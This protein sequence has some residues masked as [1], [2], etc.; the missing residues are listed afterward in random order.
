[1]EIRE[2][3]IPIESENNII[4]NGNL[5]EQCQIITQCQIIITRERNENKR[6]I[7]K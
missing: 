5:R 4:K 3:I 6:G 1:M 2:E 7:I